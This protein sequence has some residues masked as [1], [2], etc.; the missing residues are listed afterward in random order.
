MRSDPAVHPS[1]RGGRAP[2]PAARA[3]SRW[4]LSPTASRSWARCR[5]RR[6][7]TGSTPGCGWERRL[8][9]APGCGSCRPTPSARRASGRRCS[10]RSRGSARRSSRRR[11]ARPTSTPAA[12]R[13]M[14]GGHL[15]GV[16][17]ARAQGGADARPAGRGAEPLLRVRGRDAARGPGAARRSC[18]RAPSARS[19]RRCR[20]PCCPR[21]SRR[22]CAPRSSGW[23]CARSASS[24]RCPQPTWPTASA[25]PGCARASWPRGS[26]APLRPRP[27]GEALSEEIELPEA[28]SGIQL[29]RA[30]ELLIDRLL[31]RPE[32]RERALRRMRLGAR[33][34]EQGTWRREVALRQATTSR[35]R[36][37][38]ALG[39][40]LAR[41]ARADRAALPDRRRLRPAGRRPALLPPARRAGAPPPPGEA[42]RQ[43]RAA[44]GGGVG[45]ARAR[46]RSRLAHPRAARVP[47]PL[48]GVSRGPPSVPT[49]TGDGRGERGRRARSGSGAR[50]VDSVR[51]EWL[52]EDRWWTARPLR[53][54]YF[55]LTHRERRER[56]R[57][58]RPGE[59]RWY[60]PEGRVTS[61]VRGAAR[62][63]GLLV[64][65]RRLLAGGAGRRR[66]GARLRGGRAHRPRRPVRVDGV[67]ARVQGARASRRSRARGDAGR[68][69]APDAA[70]REPH[71]LLATSAAC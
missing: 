16:L 5:A 22:S 63:L 20:C 2:R 1:D 71:R 37:R 10:P 49:A 11:P 30:L 43:T 45:A 33:F 18:P 3:R 35:E 27:P 65:R 4:H 6:R 7:R 60:S 58:L 52:V 13:R 26:D 31:A 21:R 19:S 50:E 42:L 25:R 62:A 44:A 32:R 55:E 48:P 9:A 14:Y 51:E 53:R 34:V 61:I 54:R 36:L 69:I 59:R 41:A 40:R 66:G 24:R 56:G 57:V 67:R 29:Q 64:P 39:P 38:L 15:E 70:R 47:D 23:A 28:V 8:R 68:R 17:R 46:H 12:L